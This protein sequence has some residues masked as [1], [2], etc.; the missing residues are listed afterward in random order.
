MCRT[1]ST[2]ICTSAS[3]WLP[4]C[5]GGLPAMG[6]P[7]LQSGGVD[8]WFSA[9]LDAAKAVIAGE[10]LPQPLWVEIDTPALNQRQLSRVMPHTRPCRCKHHHHLILTTC[11][12][13]PPCGTGDGGPARVAGRPGAAVTAVGRQVLGGRGPTACPPCR[14]AGGVHNNTATYMMCTIDIAG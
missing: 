7:Q 8:T 4:C 10:R 2:L 3:S 1:Q 11:R 12:V 14:P 13:R 9:A 5:A 6:P